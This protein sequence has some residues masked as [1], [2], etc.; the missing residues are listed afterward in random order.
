MRRKQAGEMLI[1]LAIAVALIGMGLAYLGV[2][3]VGEWRASRG[4]L[5]GG[6][7]ADLGKGV[8]SYVVQ[9]HDQLVLAVLN[10]TVIPPLNGVAN[11]LS[12]TPAEIASVVGLPSLGTKPPL[13]GASYQIVISGDDPTQGN[14]QCVASSP[15]TCNINALTYVD[16]PLRLP[17][18]SASDDVDYVAVASA[19]QQIG[20]DGG[21]AMPPDFSKLT[22]RTAAN[23]NSIPIANPMTNVAGIVAVRGGYNRSDLNVFLRLD[24]SKQMLGNLDMGAKSIVNAKDINGGGALVMNGDITSNFGNMNVNSGSVTAALDVTAK[25]NLIANG[26]LSVGQNGNI[27]GSLGVNGNATVGGSVNA[28]GRIQTGEYLL[29]GQVSEGDTQGCNTPGLIA[30]DANGL[31]LSCQ[32][33]RWSKQSPG[34]KISIRT[35]SNSAYRFPSA[36]AQCFSSEQLTGGGAACSSPTGFIWLVASQPSGNGWQATCDTTQNQSASINVYAICKE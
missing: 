14:R 4:Q 5:L 22:F 1:G 3:Q 29:A 31:I 9:H 21:A 16:K 7:L 11:P 12:P 19:V 34:E 23:S 35:A 18:P 15:G 32:S 33:G 2:R 28:G 6:A 36:Y 13:A 24:G 30:R 10:Q 26:N 17:Y 27:N 20:P 25:R 8:Q